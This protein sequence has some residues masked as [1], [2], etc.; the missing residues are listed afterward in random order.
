M[1]DHR[2]YD[3]RGYV[4]SSMPTPAGATLSAAGD[5]TRAAKLPK[6][7]QKADIY[8]PFLTAIDTVA[9]PST[10][11]MVCLCDTKSEGPDFWPNYLRD[12]ISTSTGGGVA[13]ANQAQYAGTLILHRPPG[14]GL[15]RFDRDVLAVSGA[16]HVLLFNGSN[17]VVM[18]GFTM[19]ISNTVARRKRS[20]MAI[21]IPVAGIGITAM[22]E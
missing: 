15:T 19:D 11:V 13:V 2:P 9:T 4:P 3:T 12:R 8:S 22:A 20:L 7:E 5:F 16:T 6:T 10:R 17:D 21:P 18:P 14:T 1:E